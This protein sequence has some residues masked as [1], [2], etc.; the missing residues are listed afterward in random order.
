MLR[1]IYWDT[2]WILGLGLRGPGCSGFVGEV[3]GTA[4]QGPATGEARGLDRLRK[5]HEQEADHVGDGGVVL[6]GKTAGLAVE[7][8]GN[9]YGDVADS[10]HFV[11]C[12]AARGVRSI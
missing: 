8:V 1:G 10:L 12:L 6:D 9:G 7:V 5:G 2:N 3:C 4:K 11:F